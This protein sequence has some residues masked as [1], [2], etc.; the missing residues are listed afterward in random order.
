M[1]LSIASVAYIVGFPV[2]G[3]AFGALVAFLALL[4]G[5]RVLPDARSTG[6]GAP[7]RH[8]TAGTRSCRPC[9]ARRR[10]AAGGGE[11]VVSFGHPLCTDCQE[12]EAEV[13]ASGRRLV[14][15]RRPSPAKPCSLVRRRPV[16]PA[17]RGRPGRD[18]CGS[19]GGAETRRD[20]AGLLWRWLSRGDRPGLAR[21]RGHAVWVT[22]T[23]FVAN[24][25]V[26]FGNRASVQDK[27]GYEGV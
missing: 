9:G 10:R 22:R 24:A 16:P 3:A 17:A 1:V 21:E 2:L 27:P 14:A 4:A 18:R 6:R 26:Y 5:D 13:R 15:G 11:V 20:L 23:R 19:F 7:V 8:P 12:L 25:S